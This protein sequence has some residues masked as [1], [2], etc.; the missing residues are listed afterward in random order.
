MTGM[1]RVIQGTALG[2]LILST[3]FGATPVWQLAAPFIA[4]V[5]SPFLFIG[6]LVV[7]AILVAVL[8]PLV[9]FIGGLL[10]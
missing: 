10:R 4:V 2:L 5:A 7:G 8:S 6:V 3:V 1:T 9:F